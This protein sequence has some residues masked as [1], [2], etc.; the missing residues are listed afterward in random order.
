MWDF[1]SLL[2][3]FLLC[4]HFD[5]KLRVWFFFFLVSF[6]SG[7]CFVLIF[8]IFSLLLVGL[9][10]LNSFE[11]YMQLFWPNVLLLLFLGGVICVS[12]VFAFLA[13]RQHSWVYG[14]PQIQ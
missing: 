13:G 9:N 12:C 5:K 6:F 10:V 1:F 11:L 7:G 3:L 2:L 14:Q 4:L 8:L